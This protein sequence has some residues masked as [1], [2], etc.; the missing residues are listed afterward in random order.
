MRQKIGGVVMTTWKGINVMKGKPL[1]VANP[2]TDPQLM[3]RSALRQI[4]AIA[5]AIVAA[6]DLGFKEQAVHMSAFNAFTG[7]NLRNAFDYSAPPTA[8][9]APEDILVAQGTISPTDITSA[10]YDISDAQLNL[11][12]PIATNNPGQSANDNAVIALWDPIQDKFYAT[13]TEGT[14]ADGASSLTLAVMGFAPAA[15]TR[16]YFFFYNLTN[17]KSSDSRTALCTTQA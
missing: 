3:R 12:W 16:I 17:R 5:R 13:N 10:I 15:T 9:I 14:R 1:T 4:V 2:K 11:V 8:T 7:Y 6:I